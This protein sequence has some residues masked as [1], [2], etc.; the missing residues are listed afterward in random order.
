M[1]LILGELGVGKI[2]ILLDLV[3]DF[4]E[5]VEDDLNY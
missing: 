4:V 2:I 3:C 5:F 1:F